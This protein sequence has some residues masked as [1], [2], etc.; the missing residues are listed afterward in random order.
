MSDSDRSLF[1]HLDPTPPQALPA[2]ASDTAQAPSAEALAALA[3][4]EGVPTRIESPRIGGRLSSP[5]GRLEGASVE[6]DQTPPTPRRL[7]NAEPPPASEHEDD[8]HLTKRELIN[9]IRSRNRSAKAEF[10]AG[11]D[12]NSLGEGPNLKAGIGFDT[13]DIVLSATVSI[14]MNPTR[15][16]E[17]VYGDFDP[18]LTRSLLETCA[19][20]AEDPEIIEYR[21]L[22]YFNWEDEGN[23]G[24]SLALS[25]AQPAFDALGRGGRFRH[26][27]G[28]R[29][30]R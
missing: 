16:V 12:D 1:P 30:S 4:E 2:G 8:A 21:G 19:D 15:Q 9:R 24:A 22:T 5:V 28:S 6:A 23:V 26:G 13:R 27:D 29:G 18:D 10:L 25:G 14:D 17:V 20:C 3:E 7:R 11:F